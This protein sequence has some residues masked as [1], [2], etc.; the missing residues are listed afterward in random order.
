MRGLADIVRGTWGR[1]LLFVLFVTS[2]GAEMRV[3]NLKCE[4]A[5]NP[6]G[7]DVA[8]PRLFWQLESDV[9]GA[10]QTAWQ[11]IVASTAARLAEGHGDLWDSGRVESDR[12]TFVRYDGRALTSTQRVFWKVRAWDE[13][14]N[15]T[16]WSEP[17]EWTMGVL[18]SEDWRA[19]WIGSEERVENLL[20]RTEFAVKTG[21][22]RAI[23]HV[24]GLGHYE[25]F[26]NGEK[27]GR[28]VLA[29]GWTD[30]RKTILYDTRD[31]TALLQ[32]GRNV[33]GLSL[34]NGMYHVVRQPGRF[35]KFVG[36]FGLQ[37][38]IVQLR[39]EY[40]DG[41]TEDVT[42]NDRWKVHAGPITFSSIYGGE[43]FDARRIPEG[44]QRVGFDD[45]SWANAGVMNDDLGRLRGMTRAAEPVM[46]IEVRR[47][48]AVR[49]LA[50]GVQ[51]VDFGQNASFMPRIRV[52]GPKGS[53]VRLTGG[54]VV[55]D[56]G[57]I[58]RG[59]MGGAHRG[60]AWWQYTK[61]TD[62][63]EAWFPQF[64][65]L[66]SRYLYVE[67]QP[68][69]EGGPRPE[70]ADVEMVIVHSA[71]EPVGEF[72]ASDPTLGRI[73]ELIR[74]AQRSN[75]MSILTDCPHREK[76]GWLEQVHLNGPALRYEWDVNRLM[77]KTARDM[78]DAQQPDGLIP[79]IAPEY[80]V[81]KGTFRTAEEWGASF[82]LVPWQQY[83]FSGD[84][85]PLRENYEGMKRYFAW[86]ETRAAGGPLQ[87]GLGDWYDQIPG[88]P[89]R[90][91]LTPPA[92]T[93]TAHLYLDAATLARAAEV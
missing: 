64:Y 88:K 90:A 85:E 1:V 74:W 10:R 30:Y 65:Y 44:W 36:S 39:L 61:G 52:R 66:G 14:G 28:D 26:L 20:L 27:S 34:G 71:A 41:T 76:L 22:V 47:A 79:N 81:F 83:L 56:D 35:A 7:V 50:P 87:D 8:R 55:N 49:D 31:M 73:R 6:L 86:L 21:L 69:T 43:D 53:V 37:R 48:V 89:G 63:E 78:A 57:T 58:D 11:T 93:A 29:P 25:L 45:A 51:L 18:R 77:E 82:I 62:D 33:I 91:Y 67:L 80:T 68:A 3:V 92:L 38:A 54:E 84:T 19:T 16:A 24:S 4:L 46:P 75:L 60:S 23:A 5:R 12:T 42:T 40:A 17:A 13:V 9:R 70:L 15:V 2:A 32:P 59:T 72:T